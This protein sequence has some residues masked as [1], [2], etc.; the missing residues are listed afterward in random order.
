MQLRC[1]ETGPLDEDVV[2]VCSEPNVTL[3]D[4]TTVGK[5]VSVELF[6]AKPEDRRLAEYTLNSVTWIPSN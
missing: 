2:L 3:F 1:T 4:A 6:A 5:W